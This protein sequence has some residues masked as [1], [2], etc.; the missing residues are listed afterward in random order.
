MPQAI[1]QR[2]ESLAC[3]KNET[4]QGGLLRLP[5]W[6]EDDSGRPFRPWIAAWVSL[7]TG[8]TAVSEPAARHELGPARLL[9]LLEEF[10]GDTARAGY[11]PGTLVVRGSELAEA[12]R[13]GV[14]AGRIRVLVDE[15]AALSA[16]LAACLE[17]FREEERLDGALEQPG[18]DPGVLRAFADAACRFY[19][20]APWQRLTDQDLLRVGRPTAG[21][22]PAHLV[23]LGA[24]GIDRGAF[25]FTS[26]EAHRH[27][28]QGGLGAL[29]EAGESCWLI[30]FSPIHELPISDADLFEDLDLPVAAAAAYPVALAF[31]GGV[32][33]RRLEGRELAWVADLLTV[34][35]EGSWSPDGRTLRGRVGDRDYRL[36]M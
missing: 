1:T 18:M 17:P 6:V 8:L 7:R 5:I 27:L 2:L 20:A 13:R 33:L 16:P 32:H 24:A 26:A 25:F 3:R 28:G 14:P 36:S 4:W 23:V 9:A 34:L 12:V 30:T 19:R 31:E 29:M 15:S 35:A 11:L 22:L 21:G 10:A